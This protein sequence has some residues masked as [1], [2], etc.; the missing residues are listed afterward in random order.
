MI[1][2][3]FLIL[4]HILCSQLSISKVNQADSMVDRCHIYMS[5]SGYYSHRLHIQLSCFITV[6][7]LHTLESVN[8]LEE[9]T[10][11][12]H[13]YDYFHANFGIH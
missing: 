9:H 4:N 11:E 3:V 13:A 7:A 1:N 10:A 2:E 5:G 12:N 8:T 6:T